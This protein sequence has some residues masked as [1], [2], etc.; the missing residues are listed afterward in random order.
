MYIE[1]YVNKSLGIDAD[2]YE[3]LDWLKHQLRAPKNQIVRELVRAKI[4]EILA[5]YE[6]KL[7]RETPPEVS[8]A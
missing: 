2:T 3:G 7:P 1:S 6:D 5:Q 8:I 4:L